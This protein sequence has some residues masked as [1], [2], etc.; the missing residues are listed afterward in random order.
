[1]AYL[2]LY[3]QELKDLKI[4]D[5][6]LEKE[7]TFLGRD[8][9][10]EICLDDGS[11]S[12]RHAQIIKKKGQFIISDLKSTN[13]VFVNGKKVKT[14]SLQD[15]DEVVLGKLTFRFWQREKDSEIAE[16]YRQ[17]LIALYQVADQINQTFH[18]K[19]LLNNIIEA[20]LNLTRAERGF[21]LLYDQQRKLV[22]YA[23][24]GVEEK[25]ESD[26]TIS[27]GTVKKVLVTG[28]PLL[29][30]NL[31][32]QPEFQTQQSILQHRI[33]SIIAIPLNNKKR[34]I[35]GAIY[36]DSRLKKGLFSAE[37]IDLLKSFSNQA[38][39]AIENSR[40]LEEEKKRAVEMAE[41]AA[42]A[43]YALELERLE[44]E[45]I[46]LKKKAE[47]TMYEEL[48]GTSSS[49]QNVFS[50][51]EKIAP[52]ETTVLIEGETGT[53]KELV[54]RAIHRRSLRAKKAFLAINC[55]AIPEN[56]LEAELFG[57]EK[58]AFTGAEKQ[59]LGKFELAQGGTIFLDEVN[60]LPLPLQVK[61]LRVLQE[62][63]IERVG[64]EK[65]IK[66]D[67]RIIAATNRDLKKEVEKGNFREDLFY[68]LSVIR[69][70]LPPLRERREDI[71][72]LANYFLGILSSKLRPSFSPEI[73][74]FSPAARRALELYDWPG[75]VREL[76]N[77]IKRAC[78]LARS[79]FIEPR[80][81][82]LEEEKK[83]LKTLKEI[84][85]FIEARY[86]SPYL[87]E[88]LARHHGNITEAA[89]SVQ[90]DWKTFKNLMKKCGI[91]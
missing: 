14:Y 10:C 12:S 57:Y 9:E 1:L 54:A 83:E 35:I 36:L 11:I 34:E 90:V 6:S 21:I 20:A 26:P 79:N 56:L 19:E 42:K 84:R 89:K 37:D 51:I 23:Q 2:T 68:R 50:L 24:R 25:V 62:R 15:G 69:L 58:G 7:I 61:L 18:L 3:H 87:K 76:E 13:G 71:I 32:E 8:K 43:K 85:D 55:G 82:E 49:M 41:L 52:T 81:L 28:E 45:N 22:P 16:K 70:F 29:L 5:F 91:G 74:G 4:A 46:S 47:E 40:L 88:I 78:L 39:L 73:K 66:V 31:E 60:E 86:L 38:A 53:G 64:G 17:K 72:L 33:K 48:I 30:S 80:D 77:K 75:N 63:E 44:K 65:V 67:L 59:K 27:W